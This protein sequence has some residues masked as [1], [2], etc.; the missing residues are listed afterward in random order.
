MEIVEVVMTEVEEQVS[1]CEGVKIG[2]CEEV[3]VGC[4]EVIMS[5]GVTVVSVGVSAAAASVAVRGDPPLAMRGLEFARL[6]GVEGVFC[7]WGG[8]TGVNAERR[9]GYVNLRSRPVSSFDWPVE[10]EEEW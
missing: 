8:V 9:E 3:E 4:E 5:E 7:C 10:E 1:G 2:G 6:E